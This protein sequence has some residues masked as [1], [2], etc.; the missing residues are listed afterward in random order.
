MLNSEITTLNI[1]TTDVVEVLN[2]PESLDKLISLYG[3][4]YMQ[5]VLSVEDDEENSEDLGI[6]KE[7]SD[8]VEIVKE[9][10]NIG[11]LLL[12]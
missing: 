5:G 6:F 1:I 7:E 12:C 8:D 4:K 3:M 9:I 10:A 11:N 2:N